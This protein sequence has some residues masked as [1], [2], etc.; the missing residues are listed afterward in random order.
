MRTG[1]LQY[2]SDRT[3]KYNNNFL[4]LK[5]TQFLHQY[6]I[7]QNMR[8]YIL[9]LHRQ[10]IGWDERIEPAASIPAPQ[11]VFEMYSLGLDNNLTVSKQ[12]FVYFL[13]V[14]T[15][16]FLNFYFSRLIKSLFI[17]SVL[18]NFSI[19]FRIS[20]KKLFPFKKIIAMVISS[21]TPI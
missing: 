11:S 18:T 2:I 17:S 13:I 16:F 12:I 10:K 14:L 8:I 4:T 21:V 19:V 1:P 20:E 9:D 7:S 6:F 3:F 5:V 15:I